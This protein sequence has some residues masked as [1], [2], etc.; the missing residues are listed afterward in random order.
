MVMGAP[1]TSPSIARLIYLIRGHRVMLDADLARVYGVQ[2]RQLKRQVRRNGARF[3]SDFAF[4]LNRTEYA[5]LRCQFGTLK[6]RGGHAKHLPLLVAWFTE[7]GR[8]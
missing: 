7:D 5:A 1:D 6:E 3:P 4:T 8:A 2:V